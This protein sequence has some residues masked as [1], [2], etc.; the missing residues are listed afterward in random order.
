M[1]SLRA[2]LTLSYAALVAAALIVAAAL[3]ARF[4][5]EALARPTLDALD[6][7]ARI[8]ET[9]V[10]AHPHG[11]R[12]VV[13]R[14]IQVEAQ[15]DGVVVRVPP[16][17]RRSPAGGPDEVPRGIENLN[18]LSLLGARPHVVHVGGD[19]VVIA[20]D[21]WKLRAAVNAYF[22]ILGAC[23]L[24]SIAIAWLVARWITGQAIRPL[25]T[26][27]AELRR[28]AG[29]D[30]TPR[31]VTTA[32][33]EELG[34]LIAA[35]NGATAK[36]AAAFEER[37]YV[38]EH[39][40]RFVSDAGHEL[41]TPLTV[42]DGYLQI[43]RKTRPDDAAGRERALATLQAQTARM[44]VLVERLMVL[45]RLERPQA[46]R[47]DAVVDVAEIAADA[48]AGVTSARGGDVRLEADVAPSI[49]ADAADLHEAIGNLVDN[50]VKYGASSAVVVTLSASEN[51]VIV[52]VRDGG[53]GIPPDERARIF[54][55]FF[56]G[57]GRG[58]IEGSGLGLA[59]VERA[60]SR[61]GGRVVLERAEPGETVFAL[62]LPAASTRVRD[63][64]PLEV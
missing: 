50:A 33:R 46:V 32:E 47:S 44:R 31:P 42:I 34:S 60:A 37:R 35:Y 40:R 22:E 57:E 1:R 20:P 52:R 49:L 12:S 30:F 29:G 45:A 55:R 9:I 3:L 18:V 63:A 61:C 48:I 8:A 59:I 62:H 19:V 39:M 17:N 21:Y 41:R 24:F 26:V 56:R 10:A 43:L 58:E 27:T 23:V 25:L 28:F 14:L 11:P 5:F 7:S 51:E 6:V 15:R 53:P 36:V 4:A 2:R 54:E 38:E 13:E 16:P 64:T